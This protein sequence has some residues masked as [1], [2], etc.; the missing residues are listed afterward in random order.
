MFYF[1]KY[2][3][4]VDAF[5]AQ[6]RALRQEPTR[7]QTDGR[8]FFSFLDCCE[9]SEAD[10]QPASRQKRQTIKAAEVETS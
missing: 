3:A 9:G 8:R 2:T 5:F 4:S 1:V 6:N 10:E 7:G